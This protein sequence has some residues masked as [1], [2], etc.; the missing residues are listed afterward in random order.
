MRLLGTNWTQDNLPYGGNLREFKFDVRDRLVCRLFRFGGE[1][2]KGM[3]PGHPL[4]V[5]VPSSSDLWHE[6][7][8]KCGAVEDRG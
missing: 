4:S 7:S 5:E 2:T 3:W 6:P 1:Y 8:A